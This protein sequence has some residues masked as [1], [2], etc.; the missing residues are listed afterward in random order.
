M[1]LSV[2]IPT[3]N[4]ATL[5]EECLSSLSR[6]TFRDFEV[7]VVDGHSTDGTA[8]VAKRHGARLV[9]EDYGTRAGACRVGSEQARGEVL[10]YTDDDCTFPPDWLERIHRAFSEDPELMVYGGED[11]IPEGSSYFERTLYQFDLAKGSFRHPSLRLR[12]CNVAYRREALRRENFN[13]L[14]KG[15]EETELHYRMAKRGR[16]SMAESS[17]GWSL[18]TCTLSLP[19]EYILRKR[20]RKPDLRL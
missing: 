20:E 12:G 8:E 4:H 11:V 14:L 6:Q 13:P 1:R 9:Y 2:I 17:S 3:R 19:L 15:I 5:L 18:T 7:V 16:R 10:V